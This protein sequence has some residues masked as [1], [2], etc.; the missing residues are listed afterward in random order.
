MRRLRSSLSKKHQLHQTSGRQG[1]C[2]LNWV[3]KLAGSTRM[4]DLRP[5]CLCETSLFLFLLLTREFTKRKLSQWTV[6]RVNRTMP[7]LQIGAN[8]L[9]FASGV[10]R[11]PGKKKW[12]APP[13]QRHDVSITPTVRFSIKGT[14]WLPELRFFLQSDDYSKFAAKLNGYYSTAVLGTLGRKM[15]WTFV[16]KCLTVYRRNRLLRYAR[17]N[18]WEELIIILTTFYVRHLLL[19]PQKNWRPYKVL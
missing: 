8:H 12:S 2:Q 17:L 14:L 9:I 19:K 4:T 15:L 5:C 10:T 3:K 6:D 18:F 1:S 16:L 13:P 11:R 7:P